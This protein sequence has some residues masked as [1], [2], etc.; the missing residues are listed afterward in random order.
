MYFSSILAVVVG[1]G[2]G[3]F[4]ILRRGWMHESPI[5]RETSHNERVNIVV[6]VRNE[7]DFLRLKL[8]NLCS[9]TY[10]LRLLDVIVVDSSHD[11][12]IAKVVEEVS[13]RCPDL[14]VDVVRDDTDRGKYYSLNLAF[15]RCGDRFV[16]ISDVDVVTDPTAI[17]RLLENFQ[18]PEVGAVSAMETAASEFSELSAYRNLYNVLRVAESQLNSVVMCESNLAA[19]RRELLIELPDNVQCDDVALTAGV[20]SR[21]YRATYDP[22]VLFFENQQRL[23]RRGML[24]QKLRRGRANIH[25][26]KLI[27]AH[28]SE[29]PPVFRKVVLPFEIFIHIAGPLLLLS[30]IAALLLLAVYDELLVFVTAAIIPLGLAVGFGS[31]MTMKSSPSKSLGNALKTGLAVAYA[32]LE[33]NAILVIGIILVT[34]KGSQT[35]W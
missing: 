11:D 15:R 25:A 14:H 21:G 20:I 2:L 26:L 32:F 30:S 27:S 18:I 12:S 4:Y 17:E 5:L 33:Y 29:F 9:Q 35:K 3:Y 1:Y 22:R 34:C 8:V 28:R 24:S 13:Q 16:I 19:Y 7:T 6:P 10:P 31:I 23:S